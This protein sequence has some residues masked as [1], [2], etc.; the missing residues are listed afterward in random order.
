MRGVRIDGEPPKE[1]LDDAKKI[2]DKL[3]AAE[4]TKV[5]EARYTLELLP[6][7]KKA[8][9]LPNARASTLLIGEVVDKIHLRIFDGDSQLIVNVVPPK[10]GYAGSKLKPLHEL[11]DGNWDER[12]LK[13]LERREVY[14]LGEEIARRYFTNTIIEDNKDLWKDDRVRD[15]LLKKFNNKCWYTEAQDSVS[16]LH[17]DHF[18]PKGRK[19]D[20]RT[21]KVEDSYWWLAFE[22]TNYRICGELVNVKK[23]DVF[24][25]LRRDSSGLR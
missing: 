17:V 25:P 16:T 7:L 13:P 19:K 23:R 6:G 4:A 11:L 12:K 3:L 8:S 24:S 14:R 22:W 18:R 5:D 15:W 20:D 10:R 1:W 2:T 9:E 21:K